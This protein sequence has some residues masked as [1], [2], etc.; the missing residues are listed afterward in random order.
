MQ[1]NFSFRVE[2]QEEL[3][4][5]PTIPVL[6]YIGGDKTQKFKLNRKASELLGYDAKITATINFGMT[7]TGQLFLANTNG[8]VEENRNNVTLN[9]E[10]SSSKFLERLSKHFGEEIFVGREFALYTVEQDFGDYKVLLIDKNSPESHTT[11]DYSV[12]EEVEDSVLA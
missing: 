3:E 5:W 11:D 8:K 1:L 9:K 12:I 6:T 4:K 7:S 10:F 2:K